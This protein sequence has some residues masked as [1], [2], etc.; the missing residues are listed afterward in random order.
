MT[1]PLRIGIAG[2][3]TVG[4]GVI[5]IIQTHADTLQ[6]R[7]GQAFEIVAV[8]A[9]NRSRDRGVDISGYAWFDNA[10]DLAEQDNIDLIVELIGGSDGIAKELAFAALDSGKHFVTANKALIAH[11]GHA[12][13][14]LAEKNKVGLK[15]EAAVAGGIPI[16]KAIG[17]GLAAN[18]LFRVYGIM[19][20][21]CNY[22]LT[23]MEETG[24]DFADVLADAQRLGYAEADPTFDVDGIDTAH[25]LSILSSVAYGTK[26]N[27]DAVHTE[28]IRS[29]GAVD[30]DHAKELGYRI[31]LL[32]IAEYS[33]DGLRQRVRPCLVSLE[34]PIAHVGDAFNA[35]VAEGDFID[36]TVYEGRGAGEGP[37][38]SAVVADVIDLA[39]GFLTSPFFVPA[40]HLSDTRHLPMS[41]NEGEYYLRFHVS[42]TPG[43][44]AG[45]SSALSEEGVSIDTML[46]RGNDEEGAVYIIMV[47]HETTEHHMRRVL[48]KIG[49]LN[50]LIEPTVVMPIEQL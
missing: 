11:H 27:F 23:Q 26:I 48:D 13:A 44:V 45:I 36:R 21:T 20:G 12:L 16:I 1:T 3:G 4:A 19:N 50:S 32:G 46:Q 22:I 40:A 47:T 2:L 6:Q 18:G 7:T 8:S 31:K 17:E 25:K 49:Q 39:R 14:E 42:D 15:F 43:V 35:V 30:I 9:S 28:G 33:S 34:T 24:R 38:A 41:E 29:I 10:L 37:T 5:K